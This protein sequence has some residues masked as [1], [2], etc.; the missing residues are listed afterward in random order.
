MKEFTIHSEAE[1]DNIA[2]ELL[3]MRQTD[4]NIFALYGKMGSGKTTLVKA[5][6]RVMHCVEDAV[7]PTFAIVNEYLTTDDKVI[8]H[9]DFYRIEKPEEVYDIG[10][11][12]YFY[13]PNAL[14]FVEWPELIEGLLPEKYIKVQITENYNETRTIKA[15]LKDNTQKCT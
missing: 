5:F 13:N 4:T 10:Y 3:Q 9:F 1:L 8:F 2:K 12:D 7:S 11:E 6:C 14:I 15:E